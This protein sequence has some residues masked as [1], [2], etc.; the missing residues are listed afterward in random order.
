MASATVIENSKKT[1]I[2]TSAI[3]AY[4]LTK[5]DAS[6]NVV[7]AT[8]TSAGEVRVGLTDRAAGAG[9]ATGVVLLNGGGT[10]YCTPADT[11]VIGDALYGGA[12]GKVST[13]AD[14]A[15]IGYALDAGAADDVIELLLA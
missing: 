7:A 6:G 3:G 14:G 12:D 1:F 15:I 8:G 13:T 5:L 2:A 11:V 10:A 9:D 4:L